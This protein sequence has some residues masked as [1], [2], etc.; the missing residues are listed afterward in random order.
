M[1]VN[2][3]FEKNSLHSLI[4]GFNLA[5]SDGVRR[6]KIIPKPRLTALMAPD[7]KQGI[8][9]SFYFSTSPTISLWS[10]S[11]ASVVQ[12]GG[13]GGIGAPRQPHLHPPRHF[14]SLNGNFPR[15]GRR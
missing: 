5:V 11:G 4:V 13:L 7:R 15:V 8:R 3:I 2:P 6:G 1:K 10:T 14:H 12:C 9:G